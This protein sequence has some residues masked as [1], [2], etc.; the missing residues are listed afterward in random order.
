MLKRRQIRAI[1][2]AFHKLFKRTWKFITTVSKSVVD[3]FLR[4]VLLTGVGK[5]RQAHGRAGFVLPTVA[6]LLLVVSLVVGA[7]L[8]R[9]GSRTN[10]VIGAREEQIIY[11]AATP[12]VERARAKLESLFTKQTENKLP[13]GAPS[14]E[15]LL[16]VITNNPSLVQNQ[17]TASTISYTLPGETQLDINNDGQLDPAWYYQTDVDGD[18]RQETV[19]YA[20]FFRKDN[21]DRSVRIENGTD[22]Q[23]SNALVARN[24]PMNL[25]SGSTN[26]I[27]DAINRPSQQ[28]GGNNQVTPIKE[29]DWFAVGS[30]VL[31]KTFQVDAIVISNKAG[32]NRTV[33][34]LEFQQDREIKRLNTGAW[35]RYDMEIFPGNPFRWNGS[36]YTAGNLIVGG[37]GFFRSHLVSAPDSC[38][39]DVRFPGASE[40]T[41]Y[42]SA[43]DPNNPDF[44]GQ[45][46]SG[47][48]QTSG[49][50]G[51]SRFDVLRDDGSPNTNETQTRFDTSKDSSTEAKSFI[52]TT[53]SPILLLT[54]D[55]VQA[56]NGDPSNRNTRAPGWDADAGPGQ[57]GYFRTRKRIYNVRGQ[58]PFL[59]DTYRADDRYG[60]KPTYGTNKDIIVGNRMGQN[61]SGSDTALLTNNTID[62]LDTDLANL[63][64]DGY[65]E[66]R[67]WAEGLRLIVGQRLELG[68]PFGFNNT[69]D[70][71]LPPTPGQTLSHE[72]QQRRTLRDN[73]AAVQ[74]T[75]V[76]HVANPGGRDVPVTCIATTAHPGT[77]VSIDNSKNFQLA[78]NQYRYPGQTTPLL[79]DFFTGLGTNGWEF[80]VPSSVAGNGTVSGTMRQALQNLANAAGDPE[81]AFPPQQQGGQINPDPNITFWGDFSNLRRALS[82]NDSIA[83]KSYLHTAACTMGMLA[84]NLNYFVNNYTAYDAGNLN[85]LNNDIKA[86]LIAQPTL[87]EATP[88]EIL[89]E[90]LKAAVDSAKLQRYYLARFI[91]MKEQIARD[92]IL[93]QAESDRPTPENYVLIPDP[94][95]DGNNSDDIKARVPTNGAGACTLATFGESNDRRTLAKLCPWQSK[96][97]IL[98][99]INLSNSDISAIALQPRPRDQ[100]QLPRQDNP[101]TSPANQ[102]HFVVTD[103]DGTRIRTA[104]GDT[105]FFNGREM[106]TVRTLDIDLDLLRRNNIGSD[107]W[108]P[109]SGIVYAFR[110]DGVREDAIARSPA[111][112][113]TDARNTNPGGPTDPA[114]VN[115]VSPK[116]VDFVPDPYRRVH[117]FRLRNGQNIR[118]AADNPRGL[119]LVSDN[120]VYIQGDFNYH[121]T[122]GNSN[123]LEEFTQQLDLDGWSNFY[124]R[125]SLDERFAR[126]ATDTWRPSEIL[127]DAITILSRDFAEGNIAGGIQD[128]ADATRTNAPNGRYSF[129]AMNGPTSQPPRWLLEDG[130][131]A[132]GGFA[133][134]SPVPI[135]IDQNGRPMVCTSAPADPTPIPGVPSENQPRAICPVSVPYAG[136]YRPFGTDYRNVINQAN[137]TRVNAMLISGIVP[138][139]QNQSYGGFHNFPR[140]I[141]RWSGQTR[142]II[143][144]SFIQLNFSNY[145][146]A[147]F[148]QNAWEP[149]DPSPPPADDATNPRFINY[150]QPPGRLWGYD[151]GLQYAP[152]GP[153]ALRTIT[154]ASPRSEFY[155]DLEANDDYICR[156]RL[157]LNRRTG[158][159]AVAQQECQQ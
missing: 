18:N 96:F 41:I 147:P 13:S 133:S 111:G 14:D 130:T 151:V 33:A 87:R 56:R 142:L 119:S 146:T 50:G 3:W 34:T 107:V 51:S 124:T 112:D 122:D 135:K 11:N 12:A 85:E 92:R 82:G 47:S 106:M 77:R 28:N 68:N 121:S 17:I 75:A 134:N 57:I 103:R 31:R 137:Q 118:R 81:G 70:P 2:R 115:G 156:L 157:G 80:E 45:I 86:L 21:A 27:C 10:Q 98:K 66:R 97:P 29:E 49:F 54:Q 5:Q 19:V 129:R 120:P 93:G 8:L 76:Y 22:L 48:Y 15:A 1:K 40:I 4:T 152:A 42:E 52:D 159:D 65:W 16:A 105:G 61:V 136:S 55:K 153:I 24:G 126:Q 91:Y 63:G 104:L 128:D 89:N 72:A 144:G 6:M 43:T 148:S 44:Q 46:L 123:N 78:G 143:S 108:L 23:K 131:V 127:A 36:M 95:S 110:E 64:W 154:N 67:A 38:F 94:N 58:V 73:L 145:A 102:N 20:I 117:G 79:S 125:S 7:I 113:R 88:D 84:Y 83:D 62:P 74:A 132:R 90:L 116:A 155:R 30:G 109:N 138:S 25:L 150:Y 100:W 69:S 141:E 99:E 139:R 149:N 101:P 37:N 158:L 60:P 35:F 71:L 114:L 53:V 140:F 39:Y 59:D 9:T 26:N 32:T